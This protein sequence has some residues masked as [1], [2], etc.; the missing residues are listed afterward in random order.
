MDTLKIRV[1]PIPERVK[2]KNELKNRLEKKI[3]SLLKTPVEVEIVKPEEI[4]WATWKPIRILDL[5]KKT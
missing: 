2:D 5:T 1:A 3:S 4:E